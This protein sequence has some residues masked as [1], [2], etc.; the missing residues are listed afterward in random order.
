[1]SRSVKFIIHERDSSKCMIAYVS[2]DSLPSPDEI[3]TCV[4]RNN[5][6]YCFRT[7]ERRIVVHG[8]RYSVDCRDNECRNEPYWKVKPRYDGYDIDFMYDYEIIDSSILYSMFTKIAVIARSDNEILIAF[9]VP[10]DKARKWY[11]NF[12]DNPFGYLKDERIAFEDLRLSNMLLAALVLRS[13]ITIQIYTSKIECKRG[14]CWTDFDLFKSI[15]IHRD[16]EYA[17]PLPPLPYPG[18]YHNRDRH[19]AR[20]P[21]PQGPCCQQQSRSTC[22]CGN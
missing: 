13:N 3:R 20:L 8:K 5:G 19:I 22:G 6:L 16:A 2:A 9:I 21:N 18:D 17:P 1:M 7:R 10:C 11:E 15:Y 4:R 12:L 14:R